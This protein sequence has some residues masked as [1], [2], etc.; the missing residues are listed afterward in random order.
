LEWDR[1]VA[2]AGDVVGAVEQEHVGVGT[3]AGN[4][5]RGAGQGGAGFNVVRV[6][7]EQAERK[8]VAIEQRQRTQLVARDYA[9]DRGGERFVLHGGGALHHRFRLANGRGGRLVQR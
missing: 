8:E 1:L 5:E 4:A 6:G 9:A 3:R 7:R 2:A